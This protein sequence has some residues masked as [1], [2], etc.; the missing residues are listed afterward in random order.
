MLAARQLTLVRSMGQEPTPEEREARIKEMMSRI[1]KMNATVAALSDVSTKGSDESDVVEDDVAKE[2][3][4]TATLR[5]QLLDEIAARRIPLAIRQKVQNVLSPYGGKKWSVA[6]RA[7]KAWEAVQAANC[8]PEALTSWTPDDVA[9]LLQSAVIR[10]DRVAHPTSTLRE[11][12]SH[13]GGMVE[14]D[15]K[16]RAEVEKGVCDAIEAAT[17]EQQRALARA[18][19]RAQARM[20]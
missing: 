1:V 20:Q 13:I 12:M 17:R 19:A 14:G 10:Y 16:K 3:E 4:K 7:F 18:Q 8:V 2:R 6:D 15:Q 9:T 11:D 5:C